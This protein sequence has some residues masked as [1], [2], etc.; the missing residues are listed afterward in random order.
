MNWN[1]GVWWRLKVCFVAAGGNFLSFSLPVLQDDVYFWLLAL[2]MV[3]FLVTSILVLWKVPAVTD[4]EEL[5]NQYRFSMR[6]IKILTYGAMAAMVILAFL[7]F[8]HRQM[9]PFV[10]AGFVFSFMPAYVLKFS[11]REP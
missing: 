7:G 4:F 1:L 9:S 3:L 5:E 11:F 10:I 2:W 6:W 8:F